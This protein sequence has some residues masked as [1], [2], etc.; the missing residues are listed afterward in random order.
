MVNTHKF[1]VHTSCWDV[2]SGWQTS[3]PR[4][5]CVQS[6]RTHFQKLWGTLFSPSLNWGLTMGKIL[7]SCIGRT[8]LMQLLLT[9]KSVSLDDYVRNLFM[10]KNTC[11][12]TA[13]HECWCAY[14]GDALGWWFVVGWGV[15]SHHYKDCLCLHT[16]A[17]GWDGLYKTCVTMQY[18]QPEHLYATNVQYGLKTHMCCIASYYLNISNTYIEK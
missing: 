11:Y 9:G 1:A 13:R 6:C 14:N 4:S 16:W 3:R 5:G 17:I 10:Q 18:T 2:I 12:G 8:C 7:T 15:Q